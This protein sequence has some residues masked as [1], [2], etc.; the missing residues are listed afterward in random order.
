MKN[1]KQTYFMF[2]MFSKS[3]QQRRALAQS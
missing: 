2:E 3:A 1:H